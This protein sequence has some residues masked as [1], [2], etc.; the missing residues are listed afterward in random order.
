MKLPWRRQ[1]HP[2]IFILLL[3]VP[4]YPRRVPMGRN[5][6]GRLQRGGAALRITTG[7]LRRS[8]GALN[9]RGV[10]ARVPTTRGDCVAGFALHRSY[11]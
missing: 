9:E 3:L 6:P 2:L 8:R 5:V 11:S 10:P 4:G 7:F 1:K